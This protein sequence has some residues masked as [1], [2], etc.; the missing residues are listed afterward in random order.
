MTKFVVPIMLKRNS[1]SAIIDV[2]SVAA[3][4]GA[5]LLPIYSATKAFNLVLS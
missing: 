5:A 1:R 3:F 4:G 2:C